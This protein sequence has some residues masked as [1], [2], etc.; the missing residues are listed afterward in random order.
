MDRLTIKDVARAAGVHPATA[1]RALNPLLPGRISAETTARVVQAATELGYVVDPVGRSLRSR[2]S[3]TVGVLVPDLL[4][5]FYPPVVRGVQDVLRDHGLEALLASTDNDV[6]RESDLLEVFRARRCDGYVIASAG[7]PDAPV[8][9]LVGEGVPVVLV[10]RLTEA[11]AP[12]VTSDDARGIGQAV[13][14]LRGLGHTAIGHLAGPT[15]VSVTAVRE[16]AYRA[17][18]RGAG[19]TPRRSWVVRAG[20]YTAAAGRLA[21]HKLLDRGEVTAVLAGN[22]LI[23][24]GCYAAIAERG[25]RC[26]QDVSLV[27]INDM[28][29]AEWL[30]PALTTVAI[31]QAELG[32]QAA[33]LIVDRIADPAAAVEHVSVTTEL[34]VR[35]STAPA[36]PAA[37]SSA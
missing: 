31:D 17:A 29:L 35:E 12:S 14:H 26:P 11:T 1:S 6:R 2:R 34:V 10:N 21:C 23:A 20:Q 30:R 15:A 37:R 27:G 7:R 16:Q 22:D 5:P 4:N 13:D 32:R 8:A 19:I 33:R 3:G 18:L 28:P 24:V 36:R 9:A 25:L